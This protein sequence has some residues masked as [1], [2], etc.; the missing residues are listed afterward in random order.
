MDYLA[1]ARGPLGNPLYDPQAALRLARQHKQQRACV[2]LLWELG[3]FEVRHLSSGLGRRVHVPFAAA[4]MGDLLQHGDT[5]ISNH[6]HLVVVGAGRSLPGAGIRHATSRRNRQQTARGRTPATEALACHRLPPD[7]DGRRTTKWHPSESQ[8]KPMHCIYCSFLY[9][10]PSKPCV[11]FTDCLRR[12]TARRVR[13][14][15]R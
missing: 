8:E 13:A 5:C 15:R 6:S 4:W 11:T 10:L 3:L 14:S 9:S 12:F 1:S 7:T 2:E